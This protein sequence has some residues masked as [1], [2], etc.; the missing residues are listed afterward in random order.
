MPIE[1]INPIP[2]EVLSSDGGGEIYVLNSDAY[3][4]A[5]G[6]MPFLLATNNDRPYIR[7]V[8][9]IGSPKFDNFAEPGEYSLTEWWLRSQSDWGGGEGVTYQDP[10]VD[11]RFNIKYK[12]STGINVWKPGEISLLPAAF[13]EQRAELVGD[14]EPLS[15]SG[16]YFDIIIPHAWYTAGDSLYDMNIEADST[17]NVA[18]SGAD[19]KADIW[20]LTTFGD[21]YYVANATGIYSGVGGGAGT[22]LWNTG[23]S[24]IVISWA[25]GRLMAGIDNKIYELVGTGPALPTPKFTH[26]DADW[27]W[28]SIAEGPTAIYA[29]GGNYP[30]NAIYKF[31]LDTD[32]AVPTL[33]SGGTIAATMPP[34]EQINTL[35]CY[36]GTFVGIA[37]NRGFRV[38]IIDAQG[39]ITYGPLLWET[40]SKE[41]LGDDRFFYVGVRGGIDLNPDTDSEVPSTFFDDVQIVDEF[42]C[43]GIYRVDLGQELQ[44]SE[45]SSLR[46]AYS[47]DRFAAIPMDA[48][49]PTDGHLPLQTIAMVG[50]RFIFSVYRGLSGLEDLGHTVFW[51]TDREELEVSVPPDS[52]AGPDPHYPKMES[53]Y[54]QTG[55]VRFN[56]LEAKLF[57]FFSVRSPLPLEGEI[58]VDLIDDSQAVTRYITYTTARPPDVGDIPLSS[59]TTP[60]SYVSLRFTLHRNP[61][62]IHLGATINGWQLKALPAPIRQRSFI[63]SVSCFDFEMDKTGQNIGYEG[64]ALE[65]QLQLEQIAQR[66]N[67]ISFQE[68][69]NDLS[70]QVV[71]EEMQFVQLAPPGPTTSSIGGYITMRLKT[72]SDVIG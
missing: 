35:Y 12:Q 46:Y 32:G 19:P 2:D 11:L 16:G 28:T 60:K 41:I 45:G 5:I 6:G 14:D 7:E 49:D 23:S 29:A 10:D 50:D 67:V 17:V 48:T 30:N 44:T 53:G 4:V 1:I 57:R 72:V 55:R 37:T 39:D 70:A 26:L 13:S 68:L 15:L 36:L 24:D 51:P 22:K 31:V 40:F 34:G 3:D 8:R 25:K 52:I 58:D 63:V 9:S 43:D 61:V 27:R 65:R 59:I 47:T 54:L 38:G 33:A 42:L 56:T 66:G 18:Y 71:I 21:R 69:Y 20:S 62:D 64:Y